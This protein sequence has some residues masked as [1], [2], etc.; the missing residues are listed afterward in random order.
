M[1]HERFG[2]MLNFWN[3]CGV[4]F[5]YCLQSVYIFKNYQ[6]LDESQSL[7]YILAV[8]ASLIL[9]YYIFDS[10]NSQVMSPIDL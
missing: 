3:V 6:E 8:V 2:W 10:A 9:G 5:M 4:P 7:G 1:F